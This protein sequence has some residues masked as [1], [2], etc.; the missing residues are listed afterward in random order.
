MIFEFDPQKSEAN[1]QK[2]GIDFYQAQELWEDP[3]HII[4]PARTIDEPRYLLIGNLNNILWSVIFTTRKN[5]IRIISTRRARKNEQK[6][7]KSC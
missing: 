3:E 6:I 2:H 4:L 1:K 5:K 7:Y